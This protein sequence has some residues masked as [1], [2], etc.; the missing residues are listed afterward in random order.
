MII[1]FLADTNYG[2]SKAIVEENGIQTLSSQTEYS[3]SNEWKLKLSDPVANRVGSALYFEYSLSPSETELEGKLILDK[4]SGDFLSALNISAEYERSKKFSEKGVGISTENESEYKVE[5]AYGLSY[6]VNGSLHLGVELLNQN[7]IADS[8]WEYSVLFA[9]PCI[10]YSTS[11]F[12]INLTCLPQISNLKDVGL[13]LKDKE[14]LQT[15]L[16]FSYDF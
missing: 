3:F 16:I 15:R 6:K 11:G 13:E 8:K 5:F 4:Q 9:G 7:Q 2:Y 14:R 10:S 12:W 1:G